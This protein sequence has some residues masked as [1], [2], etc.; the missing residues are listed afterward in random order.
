[1]SHVRFALYYLPPQG[2]LSSFGARW[3]G[4]DARIGTEVPHFTL[5]GL[6]AATETPRRYGFHATLKPPFRLAPGQS[7][8][9][10]ER[11]VAAFAATCPPAEAAGLALARLG[12]FL[13]LLPEG[14][15]GAIARVAA[16]CVTGLDAFRA[17]LTE[18]ELARRRVARLSPAQEAH[19]QRWGY[20]HVL[21]Q[22]RFHMTLTGRLPA[23]ERAAWQAQAAQLL[24]PL[25]RPF[26]L[27]R[28]SLMGERPDGRFEAL[29]EHALSG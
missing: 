13:A 11:A 26:R 1:M 20:P 4:W 9:A 25:P 21:D 22:F 8:A 29:A 3:L 19:L 27:D 17:P 2:A 23:Q 14:D 12:S 10:L 18:A 6:A 24:P 5:P 15:A 16:G 28:V 7:R